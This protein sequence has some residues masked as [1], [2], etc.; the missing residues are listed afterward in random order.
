M[1]DSLGGVSTGPR[2]TGS[3][4][5]KITANFMLGFVKGQISFVEWNDG[6]NQFS[7]L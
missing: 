6:A 5:N 3:D 2:V 7:N 1:T 4:G